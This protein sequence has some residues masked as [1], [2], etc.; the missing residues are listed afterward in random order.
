MNEEL[1]KNLINQQQ[2]TPQPL[3]SNMEKVLTLLLNGIGT[4]E[5][6]DTHY[7]QN[8][9]TVY[10]KLLDIH[11]FKVGDLV[12]WK[13]GLKNKKRPHLNQPA[14]VIELLGEPL[15]ERQGEEAGS[16]YYRE[17]LDIILGLFDDDHEFMMFYYDKR[18]FEPYSEGE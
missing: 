14:I 1:L 3:S 10:K 9:R 13:E 12:K 11:E 8:L 18:R 15:R 5:Q 6:Y 7:T 17:P 16:P 4:E 2:L